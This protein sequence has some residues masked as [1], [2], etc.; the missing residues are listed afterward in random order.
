MMDERRFKDQVKGAVLGLFIGDAL[1]VGPH[2]YYDLDK[3]RQDY[4]NWID[5]YTEVKPGRYHEG[6]SAGESSQTGQVAGILLDSLTECGQWDRRDFTG[7]LDDFLDTLDG[8][9]KSGRYTDQAMRDV[10]QA[11]KKDGRDWDRAGSWADT[12]EAAIRM[13]LLACAKA[14]QGASARQAMAENVVLTHRDPFIAGQSVGFGL[15]VLGLIHGAPL[16][17]AAK[18]AQLL[19]RKDKGELT[20]PVP[21]EEER[22]TEFFDVLLQPGWAVQAV[23]DPAISIDPAHACCRLFGLACT[24]GFMLPAAFYL[25]A[26]FP[27]EFE[28]PVLHS[29]NGGGNNMARTALTGALAGAS[30]GLSGIP[31]RF[32]T[33]LEGGGRLLEKASILADLAWSDGEPRG[34]P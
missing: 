20:V 14:L 9:P 32:L 30:T 5:D 6:V 11:R 13:P 25:V 29:L 31:S 10:W 8:T 24:L 22:E 1:G 27:G 16:D 7:R 15:V 28:A 33:G 34:G 4:G 17:K 26:R 23:N 12:A 2:W 19:V 18:E 3:L 21:E